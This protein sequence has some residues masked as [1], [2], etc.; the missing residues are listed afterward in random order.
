M[1]DEKLLY[2]LQMR[3]EIPAL[4][5]IAIVH[6]RKAMERVTREEIKGMGLPA[7][8][9][10]EPLKWEDIEAEWDS[11]ILKE[12]TTQALK[13]AADAYREAMPPLTGAEN[14]RNFI[15]CVGHGLLL[16]VITEKES[17]K[18]L[19]AAQTASIA[20]A[21]RHKIPCRKHVTPPPIH[22]PLFWGCET[23]EL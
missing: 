1:I 12:R 16:H 10:Q 15:A 23:V 3:L 9:G 22:P 19:Y 14:I 21:K 20:E 5:N 13:R 11:D 8:A 2:R 7:A 4:S 17:T 18:L 6:C